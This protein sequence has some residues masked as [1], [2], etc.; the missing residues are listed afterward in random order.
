M[1]KYKCFIFYRGKSQNK[2]PP[3]GWLNMLRGYWGLL[4]LLR[5]VDFTFSRDFVMARSSFSL[6]SLIS[7]KRCCS[8]RLRV[9]GVSLGR[10]S[11]CWFRFMS[12]AS[13]VIRRCRQAWSFRARLFSKA[14][15][16]KLTKLIIAVKHLTKSLFL[17]NSCDFAEQ[18]NEAET[19][20]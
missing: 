8:R 7:C 16:F 1:Q 12:N 5:K 14:V 10:W 3:C 13:Y 15:L 11:G 9:A 4:P 19:I 2:S 17:Q 20:P 18:R 6:L